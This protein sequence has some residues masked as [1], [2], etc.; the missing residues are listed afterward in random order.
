MF[1]T[2]ADQPPPTGFHKIPKLKFVGDNRFPE[3]S[4]CALT[5]TIS[6]HYTEYSY[7]EEKMDFAILNGY[8]FGRIY[9]N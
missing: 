1:I 2:G 8:G 6:R 9:N 3:A 7:F 4:T 5:L